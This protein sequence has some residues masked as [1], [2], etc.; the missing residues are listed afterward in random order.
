MTHTHGQNHAPATDGHQRGLLAVIGPRPHYEGPKIFQAVGPI[1]G[2]LANYKLTSTHYISS[3][4]F[5]FTH[6]P[7]VCKFCLYLKMSQ[8]T[9][10]N[11]LG[12][13]VASQYK[14][15]T[16]EYLAVDFGMGGVSAV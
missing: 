4:T 16:N 2:F 15:K 10:S 14:I 3:S 8:K 13:V 9:F 6:L 1:V 5:S 12:E 11:F 7:G